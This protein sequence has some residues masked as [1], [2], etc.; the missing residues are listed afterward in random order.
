TCARDASL[1]KC[2]RRR[3]RQHRQWCSVLERFALHFPHAPKLINLR[4]LASNYENEGGV[5]DPDYDQNQC[6]DRA[7]V[8]GS[9]IEGVHVCRKRTFGN[10]QQHAGEKRSDE[11]LSPPDFAVRQK[12][13]E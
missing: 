8:K 6:S 2:I 11:C 9:W 7:A 4:Y 1:Q 5:V 3:I 13:V 10:L 12:L